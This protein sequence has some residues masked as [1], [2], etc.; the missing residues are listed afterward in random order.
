MAYKRMIIGVCLLLILGLSIGACSRIEGQE[1]KPQDAVESDKVKESTEPDRG[2]PSLLES[3]SGVEGYLWIGPMCPVVQEGTDCPDKPYETEFT[4]TDNESK[5]VTMSK[6]DANGFFHIP[7][8]P[9]SY[10][11]VP[12]SGKPGVVPMT[13]PIPFDVTLGSFTFLEITFDSGI[14]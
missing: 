2:T 1:G 4:I 10:V 8:M 6:S 14:R 9:G 3:E 13:E 12:K 11:F 7:L 5:V